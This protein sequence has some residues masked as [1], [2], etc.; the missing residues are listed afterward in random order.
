MILAKTLRLREMTWHEFMAMPADEYYL[1]S[2]AAAIW[3]DARREEREAQA[4]LSAATA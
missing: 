2:N 1:L 4:R 3:D